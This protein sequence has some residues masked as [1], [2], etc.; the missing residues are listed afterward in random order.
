[1]ICTK[2]K[3][4]FDLHDEALDQALPKRDLGGFTALQVT[5]QIMG[6]CARCAPN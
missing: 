4:V 6:Y 3:S 1:M 5:V 2:C